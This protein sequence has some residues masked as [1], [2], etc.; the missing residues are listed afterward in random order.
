MNWDLVGA[1]GE[2]AGAVA[3]VVT[4]FYLAK[5][6]RQQNHN[7]DVN[8]Q[9]SILDGFNAINSHLATDNELSTL[10]VRGLY[11]PDELSD[12]EA[13]QFQW[14]F[15]LYA[16]AYLKIHRLHERGVISDEDWR[17]HAAHAAVFF[18]TPG[19]RIWWSSQGDS[20]FHRYFDEII[21]CKTDTP[22]LD[23]TLGR[24]ENWK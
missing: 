17:G 21:Q 14:A 18:D 24:L 6:I 12:S 16:N 2:W 3:V 5:Q 1:A 15:R 23:L 11:K 19:G 13:A 20:V 7:N 4:L 22:T 10:F 8:L 9:E